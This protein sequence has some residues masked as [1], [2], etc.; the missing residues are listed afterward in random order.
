MHICMCN[1]LTRFSCQPPPP[2][3]VINVL[4]HYNCII[5]NFWEKLVPKTTNSSGTGSY[6]RNGIKN[7]SFLFLFQRTKN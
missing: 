2:C 6:L 5:F 4:E 1:M 3:V 7:E